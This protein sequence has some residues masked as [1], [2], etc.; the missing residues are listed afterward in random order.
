MFGAVLDHVRKF[1]RDTRAFGARSQLRRLVPF[2]EQYSI[3]IPNVGAFRI[4]R[5][6]SDLKVIRQVF[7]R[8]DYD[9]KRHHQWSRIWESYQSILN[10][11]ATPL[12]VDAGANNGASACWFATVFPE[13]RIVAVEPDAANARLCT[14]NTASFS[15]IDVRLAAIGGEGGKVSIS[16]PTGEA[17]AA[18]TVRDG[19]AAAVDVLTVPMIEK[20]V[21]GA[22]L[23]LVKIDIEGFESDLFS[24][25]VDWLQRTSVVIIEPHDWMLPGQ[26]SSLAL[27]RAMA[28]HRFELLVSG[29]NL[30]YV[31]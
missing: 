17:W 16:N 31:H 3:D 2:N 7:L 5:A 1:A 15:Q 30:V 12:I 10:R 11:G 23:F 6:S 8:K 14:I 22:E 13:S 18:R 28:A 24:K 29:E 4:R 19:A 26:F 21:P 25:N 20:S 9:L 27:Q